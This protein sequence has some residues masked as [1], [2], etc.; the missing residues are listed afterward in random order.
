M[1]IHF[2]EVLFEKALKIIKDA[3]DCADVLCDLERIK[4]AEAGV[5]SYIGVFAADQLD[6]ELRNKYDAI[7]KMLDIADTMQSNLI[8]SPA[9]QNEPIRSAE[10][11]AISK[12]EQDRCGILCDTIV[13]KKLAKNIESCIKEIKWGEQS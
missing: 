6:Q 5:Y 3:H 1:N 10:E 12:L 13:K 9:P 11:L 8:L 4:Q 2:D 7:D